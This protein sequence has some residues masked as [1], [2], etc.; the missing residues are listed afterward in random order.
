[1]ATR[2]KRALAWVLVLVAVCYMLALVLAVLALVAAP[3]AALI[4]AGVLWWKTKTKGGRSER[5]T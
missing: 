1:M 2:I 4:G 3:M 5:T